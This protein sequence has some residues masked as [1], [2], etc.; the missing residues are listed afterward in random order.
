MKQSG[1]VEVF[2]V[3]SKKDLRALEK[4]VHSPF[5]NKR[6]DV[7]KLFKYLRKL[8]PFTTNKGLEKRSIYRVVFPERA[9]DDKILGYAFSFLLKNIKG[10]LAYQEMIENPINQHTQL[11]KALRKKGAKRVLER[12]LK[13]AEKLLA[14]QPLRNADY[15]FY[16]YQISSE[17]YGLKLGNSRDLEKTFQQMSERFSHYFITNR[18]RIGSAALTYKSISLPE[19][20]SLLL[21]DI[22]KHVEQHDYSH[23]PAISIYYHTFKALSVKESTS[24][25]FELRKLIKKHFHCFSNQEIRDIYVLTI[26]Y[27]IRQSN[28]G[29]DEFLET[30]FE[31][32][33]DGLEN[34]VFI[35][36]NSISRFTYKNIVMAGLLTKNFNW[37]EQFLYDY[38]D[39]I[40]IKYRENTFNYNLAILYYRKPDYGKAMTLLQQAE[41]NDPLLNLNA[42]RMLL[43]IYYTE[44][45]YDALQSHL[46]SFKN[47]IY[48]HKELGYHRSFNLNLIKFTRKLLQLKPDKNAIDKLKKEVSETQEIAEK[49]WLLEQIENFK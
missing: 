30:L 24:Y 45:E 36:N 2:K 25:F 26:N 20:E 39:K 12:E 22:L 18:L 43:T 3:L 33:K 42:R 15:H 7:I 34:G 17:H 13:V 4:Y 37:V 23:V 29:Q 35:Q 38:K 9:Y 10:Y 19:S 14:D 32:Y 49:S 44:K 47:Y 28:A 48:R 8:H 40:E 5:F 11:C 31:I 21:D 27:C 1:L 16:Q 41:F 6:D 46:D